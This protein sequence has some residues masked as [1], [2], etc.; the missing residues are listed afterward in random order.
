MEDERETP[1]GFIGTQDKSRIG[2]GS[3][4][5]LTLVLCDSSLH[6]FFHK[7]SR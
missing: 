2:I 6:Q 7:C 3:V 5:F 1:V 4:L